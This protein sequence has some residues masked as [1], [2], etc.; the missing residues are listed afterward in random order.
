M[1]VTSQ[2]LVKLF[3][4]LFG[5]VLNTKNGAAGVVSE[6]AF[7]E[8][9]VAHKSALTPDVYLF[10]LR[11]PDGAELPAFSPG[12]HVTVVLPNGMRRNYSLS[13]DPADRDFYQVAV[14]RDGRGRGGSISMADDVQVGDVLPTSVPRNNFELTQ[15]ADDYIFV[16]G[17]IGITPI[18]SMMRHL[19][20]SGRA[21][22]TLYYCTR[23]PA[24]TAFLDELNKG[25]FAGQVH[26]HHDYGN[27]DAAFDFWDIFAKPGKAHVYCCGPGGLMDSVRDTSGHWPSGSVHFE[28][29][30]VANV[31]AENKAFTVRLQS[32]GETIPVGPGQSILDALRACGH[33]V[34]SSCESGTCGSC[35]TALVAGEADHRDMVLSDAEKTSRIMVCVSRAKSDQLVL[36]L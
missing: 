3:S 33:H 5:G 25:E 21:R 22:F 16:A 14:K 2:L 35:R 20:R 23:D 9:K 31:H 29:F 24:S 8:L 4:M 26:F 7:M 11:H 30:G 36:G 15:H 10:E 1:M 32:S 19:K 27:L 28:S 12:S 34:P 17:G 13:S 6:P 18:L